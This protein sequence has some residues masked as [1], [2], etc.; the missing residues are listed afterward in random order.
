[1]NLPSFP[2][3]WSNFYGKNQILHHQGKGLTY[4]NN[5]NMINYKYLGWGGEVWGGVDCVRILIVALQQ[6]SC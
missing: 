3:E 4:A 6:K 5:T 2:G 1:M